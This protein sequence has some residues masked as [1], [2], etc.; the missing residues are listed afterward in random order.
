[1]PL[2]RHPLD[3][4]APLTS[5]RDAAGVAGVPLSGRALAL[6]RGVGQPAAWKAEQAG[7]AISIATLRAYVEAL[8]GTLRIEVDLPAPGLFGA[9]GQP[10]GGA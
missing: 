6:A 4:A 10:S 8:G 5:L 7:A 9:K 3:P 1:M 2:T